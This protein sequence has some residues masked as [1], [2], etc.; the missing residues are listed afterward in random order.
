MK[1]LTITTVFLALIFASSNSFAQDIEYGTATVTEEYCVSLDTESPIAEH[2]SID[3]SHLHLMTELEAVNKF[4]FISNN[5]LTYTVDFEA[6]TAYLHVHLD[7]TSTPEDIIW[8]ND[9]VESLC[10][11]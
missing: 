11:L 7:R 3:I 2:Y 5:L 8:W 9:Y 4:G 10:G 1:Y 6:E